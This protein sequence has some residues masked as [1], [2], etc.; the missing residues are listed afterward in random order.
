MSTLARD[1]YIRRNP[2]SA[3]THAVFYLPLAVSAAD[4][5]EARAGAVDPQELG[6][7]PIRV[8]L[9]PAVL[10]L[11]QPLFA[12]TPYSMHASRAGGG[13]KQSATGNVDHV[14]A[15]AGSM[16][17]GA[18]QAR[19]WHFGRGVRRVAQAHPQTRSLQPHTEAPTPG[20][21]ASQARRK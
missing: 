12:W 11:Q 7:Q 20:H 8:L 5:L 4:A 14:T 15:A 9:Q 16:G 1:S 13:W 21:G 10:V 6:Q 19:L 2:L 3:H 18:E 17:A